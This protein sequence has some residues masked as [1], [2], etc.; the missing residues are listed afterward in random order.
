MHPNLVN[1]FGVQ[2]TT[3]GLMVALGFTT[4]WYCSVTRGRK[5]GYSPD[6]IQNLLTIIVVF[7]MVFA[8]LLYIWV[9]FGLFLKNPA[10]MIFSRDGY[11][12]LGG[13]I[14]AVAAAAWYARRNGKPILGVAD[15][16]APYLALA[17]GVGRVGCF[18]FGCCYGKVCSLPW[19]VQFPKDSPAYVDHVNRG[20]IGIDSLF[21]LPVHPVQ[22]YHS[23]SNVAVFGILIWVRT[24]Q[25]F[26][27]QL[28]M[29]YL[30]LYG[31]GRFLT[32]YARG[33]SR[34]EWA[35]LSTSQWISIAIIAAGAA[36][37]IVL[38]KKNIPP[39]TPQTAAA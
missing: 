27:G 26:R 10:G 12:F 9:N 2:I 30:V 1:L 31:I 6:F 36:G 28:A 24:R 14:G 19:A 7:A 25:S 35:W 38:R 15:L 5:L 29:G 17:H 4:L 34:G 3:Y 18:L 8:R 22:L 23:F 39:E 21:S 13:F 33:D 32:E 16:F 11:V 37:Y 20:W